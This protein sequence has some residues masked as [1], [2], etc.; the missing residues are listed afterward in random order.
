[1]KIIHLLLLLILIFLSDCVPPEIIELKLAEEAYKEKKYLTAITYSNEALRKDRFNYQAV[2]IK[3]KSNLQLKNYR[4]AV[5]NFSDAIKIKSTF[6]PY[7]YRGRAYLELNELALS[8]NDFEKAIDYERQN[9]EIYFNL[10][11]VKTLMGEYDSALNLY[12]EVI[13][14]NPLNSNAYVNIGNLK[15]VMGDS[16]SAIEY[17]SKAIEVNP[18]D[19]VAYFDRAN[20]K[21]IV[22]NLN[23]AIEDFTKAAEI[24]TNNI[25]TIFILAETKIK[26]KDFA[27]AANDLQQIINLDS[28]NAKAYYM[29][30]VSEL[31]M[32]NKTQACLNLNK[33]GDLGYFDAYELIKKNCGK[34]EKVKKKSKR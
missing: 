9:I 12:N 1:M 20:E 5:E 11:Y 26:V 14:L 21:L 13:K 17:F 23:G 19:A 30:G 34:K 10:A 15:G 29:K 24:D 3:G 32:N 25:N 6:D 8:A 22:S 4:E 2:L 28:L 31:S 27:G 7:R 33:A 18:N 16:K